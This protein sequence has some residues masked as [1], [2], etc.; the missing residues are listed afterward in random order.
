MP[1]PLPLVFIHYRNSPYLAYTLTQARR[2]SPRSPIYL[3][4]DDTNANVYPFVHHVNMRRYASSAE[5]FKKIYRHFSPNG[6]SYELF[7]F[8]R[9]FYLRD[10]LREHNVERCVHVDSDV[11]LYVDV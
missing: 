4:G 11:L 10:F 7:C 2:T 5:A 9:W 8:V 3:S 6:E 1:A